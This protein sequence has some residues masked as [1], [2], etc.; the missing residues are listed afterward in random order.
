MNYDAVKILICSENNTPNFDMYDYAI[1]GCHLDFGDRH[2]RVPW[3][4]FYP[5]CEDLSRRITMTPAELLNR[6]F[7]SFVV[8]NAEFGDPIRKLFFEQLSKYKRVDSGGLWRNNIGGP[9]KDKLAFCR[10]Y[11]F[12]IAFENSSFDGYTTEKIK[13]AYIAQTVPIY[14]GNPS[15]ETDF[16]PS[17][18]VRVSGADDIERAVS[19]ICRLDRDDEAYLKMVSA[20]CVLTRAAEYRHRVEAFLSRILDQEPEKVRRIC[21]YGQQM[22]YRRHLKMV[23]SLDDR[24]C[25]S[26]FYRFAVC[27]RGKI[28]RDR[29]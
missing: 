9:V 27:L 20:E 26:K 11:K 17:S 19:E 25:K 2:V 6:K 3:F 18:M 12:N 8:S 22:V 5:D 16:N 14:Y 29:A 21:H 24:I 23:L 4:A 10:G 7:C 28:R 1:S 15:I 13:D